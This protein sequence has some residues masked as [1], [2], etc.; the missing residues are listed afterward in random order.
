MIKVN[1]VY[2]FEPRERDKKRNRIGLSMGGH[3]WHLDRKEAKKLVAD[4]TKT[5]RRTHA[6][7]RK[8][9]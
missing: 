1:S 2:E 8:G 5:L 9:K 4:L 7:F 3:V 6:N